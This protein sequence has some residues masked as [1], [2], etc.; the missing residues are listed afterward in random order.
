MCV[1]VLVYYAYSQSTTVDEVRLAPKLTCNR[2]QILVCNHGNMAISSRCY[3]QHSCFHRRIAVS[4]AARIYKV[5]L[6]RSTHMMKDVWNVQ[7]S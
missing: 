4:F 5:A 2:A 1:S 3:T 7:H 6:V